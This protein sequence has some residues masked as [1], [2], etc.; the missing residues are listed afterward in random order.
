MEP[1]E[2]S[3][4]WVNLFPK[5]FLA[6]KK[7]NVAP[8]AAAV[9]FK[10]VPKVNPNKNPPVKDAIGDPGKAKVTRVIYEI[11]NIITLTQ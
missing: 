2:A 4:R 3:I 6:A 7:I 1:S 10:K 8:V 5:P 11:I 9:T